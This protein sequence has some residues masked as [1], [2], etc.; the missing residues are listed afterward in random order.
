MDLK[1]RRIKAGW[2]KTFVANQIK[3]TRQT[4]ANWESG[5]SV[6]TGKNLVALCKLYKATAEELTEN[7]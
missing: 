5:I 4:V 1:A 6:P 2:S 3:V 7:D